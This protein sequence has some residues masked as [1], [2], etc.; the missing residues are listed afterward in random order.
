LN[1]EFLLESHHAKEVLHHKKH[2]SKNFLICRVKC[3]GKI[4]PVFF[5]L[6]EHNAMKAYWG[7][8]G[9]DPLILDPALDGGEWSASRPG[10]FTLKEKAPDTHWMGGPQSWFGRVG[11]NSQ[12]LPG[13]EPPII[14]PVA[15]E[16]SR[17]LICCVVMENMIRMLMQYRIFTVYGLSQKHI[18]YKNCYGT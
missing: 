10:R 14:Q 11:E 1:L 7:S 8:G 15:T 6:T 12:P 16:L 4:V 18:F 9:I 13:L 17:L 5:F 2:T 3:K